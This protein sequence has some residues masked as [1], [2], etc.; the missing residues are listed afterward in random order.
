MK[1]VENIIFTKHFRRSFRKISIGN[2]VGFEKKYEIFCKDIFD[3]QLK[4]HKLR[5][6]KNCWSFS[7]DF[8]TRAI[9]RLENDTVT[10]LEIGDH[11]VYDLM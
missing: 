1:R 2:R 3:P 9:F 6:M 10:F 5:G 8:S 4:T 11:S 7:V